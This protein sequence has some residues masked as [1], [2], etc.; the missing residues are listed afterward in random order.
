MKNLLIIIT[1]LFSNQLFSVNNDILS[2]IEEKSKILIKNSQLNTIT[3]IG[4]YITKYSK[5]NLDYKCNKNIKYASSNLQENKFSKYEER[6]TLEKEN[7]SE[8]SINSNTHYNFYFDKNYISITIGSDFNDFVFQTKKGE[9][10]I[11]HELKIEVPPNTI[12]TNSSNNIF[13]IFYWKV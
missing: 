3:M 7:E 2:V 13:Y 6:Y 9:V 4:C 12:I 11:N 8:N 10:T 1:I 5:E